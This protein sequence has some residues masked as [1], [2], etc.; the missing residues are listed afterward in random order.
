[1]TAIIVIGLHCGGTSAVAGVLY[2][3][4]VFMGN[5]LLAPALNNPKGHFEDME[6]VRLHDKI[7]GD[8][9][10]PKNNNSLPGE[11]M[12]LVERRCANYELWGMKDPRTI[13]CM[14]Q[15]LHALNTYDCDYRIIKVERR[16][17]IAA[18]SLYHRG[19]HTPMEA[20]QISYHYFNKIHEELEDLE[21]DTVYY[22]L[23]ISERAWQVD[24]IS[25]IIGR[26]WWS[27]SV[28]TNAVEF[29]DPSLRHWK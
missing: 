9:R 26:P 20:Y 19:G 15:L 14:S 29:I 4:G 24:W 16:P 5:E 1:M 2:H 12:D 3:L 11:Y 23:L 6:F 25:E 8:W 22:D 7:I 10:E 21:H 18:Q 17:G 13:W 28:S 27:H